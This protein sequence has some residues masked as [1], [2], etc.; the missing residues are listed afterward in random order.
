MSVALRTITRLQDADDVNVSLGAGVD[1]YALSWDNDTAKFVL[2]NMNADS[3]YMGA[4]NQGTYRIHACAIRSNVGTWEFI[5]D[6][7]HA[8][9][10]FSGGISQDGSL[11]T[12]SYGVTASKILTGIVSPDER[13]AGRFGFGATMGVSSLGIY[14]YRQTVVAH[15]G[16]LCTKIADSPYFSVNNFSGG[17]GVPISVSWSSGE[18]TIEHNAGDTLMGVPTF[19]PMGFLVQPRSARNTISYTHSYVKFYDMAGTQITDPAALP[20]GYRFFLQRT[21]QAL[22]YVQLN[23]NSSELQIASS[24]LWV[25]AIIQV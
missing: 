18:L 15:K 9:L 20:S 5:E 24:N 23:P 14:C 11:I 12:L 16:F 17:A 19:D 3:R 13:Y 21:S 1:E 10:G 22:G 8:R 25:V 6:A 4:G 2:A 7:N